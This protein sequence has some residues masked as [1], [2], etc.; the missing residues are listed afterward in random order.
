MPC[1]GDYVGGIRQGEGSEYEI[2]L[3]QKMDERLSSVFRLKD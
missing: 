1:V 3:S 2:L